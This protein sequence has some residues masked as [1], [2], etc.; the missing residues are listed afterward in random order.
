MVYVSIIALYQLLRDEFRPAHAARL[1]AKANSALTQAR[2]SND[3]IKQE[4][5]PIFLLTLGTQNPP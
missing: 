2:I 3:R 4:L 5:I 1:W